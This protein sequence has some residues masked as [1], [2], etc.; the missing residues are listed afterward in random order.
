[1]I[2]TLPKLAE[3]TDVVVI[4][5]WLVSAGDTVTAGQPLAS[6]ETDKIIVDVP[7]PVAGRVTALLADEGAEIRTGDGICEV[8]P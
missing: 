2:V 7:A 8:E 6:V 5:T 3:T 4:D 1:M